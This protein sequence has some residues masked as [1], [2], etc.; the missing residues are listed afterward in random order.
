MD[1]KSLRATITS[2]PKNWSSQ[3]KK[4]KTKSTF[5]TKEL[6]NYKSIFRSK[7]RIERFH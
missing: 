1:E 4:Q 7:A 3:L 6:I 5:E 2:K